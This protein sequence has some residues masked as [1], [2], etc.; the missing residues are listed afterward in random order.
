MESQQ[1]FHLVAKLSFERLF[2]VLKCNCINSK[3]QFQYFAEELAWIVTG[4]QPEVDILG[5][6]GVFEMQKVRLIQPLLFQTMPAQSGCFEW[7]HNRFY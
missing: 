7:V 2:R 1:T 5:Q 6:N 4:G 3:L